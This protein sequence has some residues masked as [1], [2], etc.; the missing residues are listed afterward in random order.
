MTIADERDI[1]HKVEMRAYLTETEGDAAAIVTGFFDFMMER[2]DA[3]PILKI[4]RDSG[5]LNHLI[6]KVSPGLLA[7]NSRRDKEFLQE[8]ATV[9]QTKHNL[10]SADVET[11]EG[12]MTLMLSLSMQSEFIAASTDYANVVK[13]LRDMFSTHLLQGPSHD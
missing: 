5:E 11:L 1:A 2:I 9:L 13:L 3:D 4:V 6:R 7:E 10:A 12:L 8:V